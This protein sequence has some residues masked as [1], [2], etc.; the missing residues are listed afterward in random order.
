MNI[1]HYIAAH[2]ALGKGEVD[3]SILSGSTIEA[4]RNRDF[5]HR[6]LPTPSA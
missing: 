2:N 1:K 6:S 4:F 3:S 5:P